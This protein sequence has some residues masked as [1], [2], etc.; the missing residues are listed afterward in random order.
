MR[1]GLLS[2][3]RSEPNRA[4][5]PLG[6]VPYIDPGVVSPTQPTV[7]TAGDDDGVGVAEPE[8]LAPADNATPVPAAPPGPAGGAPPPLASTQALAVT[9]TTTT[10]QTIPSIVRRRRRTRR[11]RASRLAT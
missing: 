7:M 11:R 10:A 8:G 3:G 6:A 1:S 9:T 2:R 4:R 5:P